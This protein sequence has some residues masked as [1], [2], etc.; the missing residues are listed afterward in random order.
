MYRHGLSKPDK[1][2]MFRKYKSLAASISMVP[3]KSKAI[4]LDNGTYKKWCE[5]H[6]INFPEERSYLDIDSEK[7]N[8]LN[9]ETAS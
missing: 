8:V 9:E 7:V 5:S 2:S 1:E 6:L 4:C 3:K